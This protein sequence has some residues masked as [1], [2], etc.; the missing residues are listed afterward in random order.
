M[1]FRGALVYEMRML[2]IVPHLIEIHGNI[3]LSSFL[4]ARASAQSRLMVV[5]Q[6]SANAGW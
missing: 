6:L 4:G 5:D 2:E 1:I 3:D